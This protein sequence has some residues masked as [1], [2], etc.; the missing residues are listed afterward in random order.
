MP[1]NEPTQQI[2]LYHVYQSIGNLEGKVDGLQDDVKDLKTE[3][4]N[5]RCTKE[6]ELFNLAEMIKANKSFLDAAAL[7]RQEIA[8]K[9]KNSFST[10]W[11]FVRFLSWCI[12]TALVVLGLMFTVKSVSDSQSNTGNTVKA[13]PAAPA[14]APVKSP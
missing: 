6:T 5:T 11:L 10:G 2:T 7:Q 4:R 8:D 14:P 9:L 13:A 12:G 1:G 3:V